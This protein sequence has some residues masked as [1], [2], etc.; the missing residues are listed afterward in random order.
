LQRYGFEELEEKDFRGDLVLKYLVN[1]A[2]LSASAGE[3]IL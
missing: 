2:G 3:S 1:P